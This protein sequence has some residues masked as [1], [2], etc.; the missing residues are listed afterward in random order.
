MGTLVFLYVDG[1]DLHL[2]KGDSVGLHS[3]EHIGLVL[4]PVSVHL[5]ERFHC[6]AGDGPQ[7]RLGIGKGYA[8]E[9]LEHQGGGAVAEP[10]SGGHI[11]QG[12][13]PAAQGHAAGLQHVN[14]AGPGIF[15]VVLVV[16]VHGD[17]P[18][19]LRTVGKEP[20]KS[21]FQGGAFAPVYLVGQQG[22]LR[23]SR[24][25]IGK[26]VQLLFPAAVIDK[27]NILKAIF[28]EPVNHSGELFIRVQGGQYNRNF[29]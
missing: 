4:K 21:G 12:K 15:R 2:V 13:I 5:G 11:R 27:D 16:P 20:G 22:N 9:Q 18:Q 17:N 28:Q 25:R 23:M 19:P 29:G 3:Q 26:V 6:A 10:A 8:A 1:A 24:C 14:S 7:T